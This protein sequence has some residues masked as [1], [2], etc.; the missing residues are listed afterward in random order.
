MQLPNTEGVCVDM[1]MAEIFPW[2]LL[3]GKLSGYVY[4]F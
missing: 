2:E 3:Y 4:Y 1:F